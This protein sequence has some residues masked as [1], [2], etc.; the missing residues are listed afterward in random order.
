[1]QS[2][3]L[4]LTDAARSWLGK[5]GRE[6]ISSWDEL[7]RWFTS[8]FNSTYKRPSSIEKVKACTQKH[9]ESLQSYI[10]QWS[11][12]KS[13]FLMKEQLM[14]SQLGYDEKIHYKKCVHW[15]PFTLVTRW[16]LLFNLWPSCDQKHL[17][18]SWASLTAYDD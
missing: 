1:M 9:N 3:Q 2:L 15:R 13:M 17:V 11:I 18:S 8:N 16:S 7:K 5:L 14:L 10:Q 4:H 6:T 12:T